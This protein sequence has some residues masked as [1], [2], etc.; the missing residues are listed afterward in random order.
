MDNELDE[1]SKLKACLIVLFGKQIKGDLES[2]YSDIT[3]VIIARYCA[4]YGY[5]KTLNE[6][7]DA[8][9]NQTKGNEVI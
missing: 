6:A 9:N 4:D 8:L 2:L 5:Y 7:L 1:V 3:H